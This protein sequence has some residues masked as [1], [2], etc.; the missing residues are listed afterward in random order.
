MA[1]LFYLF[2][3]LALN[4]IVGWGIYD[5]TMVP[6]LLALMG[7]LVLVLPIFTAPKIS[8]GFDFRILRDPVVVCFGLYF[9]E[10]AIS[11]FF[12]I[13]PTAGF[14]DLF[15]TFGTFVV[16]CLSCLLLVSTPGWPV[17]LSRIVTLAA[18]GSCGV[19]FYQIA[20]LFGFGFPTRAEAEAV[21]GLMSNVNLYAGFLNLLLPFC[22]CGFFIQRGVWRW[23]SVLAS[24]GTVLL[25]VLLQSRAAYLSLFVGGGVVCGMLFLFRKSFGLV[26]SRR[27]Q[28]GIACGVLILFAAAVAGFAFD[29]PAVQR[30]RTIFTSDFSAIDGGRLMIWGI[31]LE[32]IRDCFWTGVGAG[33]FTIRMHEYLGQ[34][35][36]DFSGKITNWAQPHHDFLWVFS[37][38]GL[39]GF[40]SF[41]AVF[42]FAFWRAFA[43]IQTVRYRETAWMVLFSV[44]GL[45]AYLTASCFDFPLERINQQVYLAVLLSIVVSAGFQHEASHSQLKFWQQI[46]ACLALT[47]FALLGTAYGIIAIRQEYQVNLA[48]RAL[49]NA[50][51]SAAILHARQA[52]TRW[53]TLDPVA[54]PVAF[55]EGYAFWKMGHTAEALPLLQRARSDN[56]NRLYILSTL[57]QAYTRAGLYAEALECLT[58][59]VKLY[60][61]DLEARSALEKARPSGAAEK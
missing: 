54:T 16:L 30:I 14:N 36:Q 4:W 11:L 56:P 49:R 7:F 27:V 3:L 52:A 57:G 51:F 8:R 1:L 28:A 61:N 23:A 19:G 44:M 10:T 24:V 45:V 33:N 5:L 53:K 6:R 17:L 48:R 22:L 60:P 38:K 40:L 55:L 9:A 21:T 58:L 50:D 39:L 12:A 18:F 15:K 13:N 59:A 29:V 37:E 41:L 20:T 2:L 32:M 35:G 43:V 34:P 26:L 31:T 42:V 46:A 25:I 47:L